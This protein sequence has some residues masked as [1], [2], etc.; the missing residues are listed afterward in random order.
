MGKHPYLQK[1][2]P[3]LKKT[4]P[5]GSTLVSLIKP[6]L[7]EGDKVLD[8]GCGYSPMAD[9][10]LALGYGVTGFDIH[11]DAIAHLKNKQP[12]GEWWCIPYEEINF[13]GYTVL[14]LLGAGDAWNGEDFHDYILRTITQNKIRLILLEMAYTIKTHPR[15]KGY[16]HALDTL[17]ESG[18]H[19]IKAGLYDSGMVGRASSRIFDI[20]RDRG[21]E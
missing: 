14:L 11:P 19:M 21:V 1:P 2:E 3:Y 15:E 18:Y 10:L 4:E 6:Y 13:T 8:S 7:R 5:R 12:R 17:I 16:F 20:L 9:T